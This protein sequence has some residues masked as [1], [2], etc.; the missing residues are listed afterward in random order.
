MLLAVPRSESLPIDCLAEVCSRNC[1]TGASERAPD[2]VLRGCNCLIN[3]T[4]AAA[5]EC[6][7]STLNLFASIVGE[8]AALRCVVEWQCVLHSVTQHAVRPV[9]GPTQY[10]AA[11]CKW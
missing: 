5:A 2:D 6:S 3:L 11:P 7:I 1:V 8:A 4:G 9:V 10:P